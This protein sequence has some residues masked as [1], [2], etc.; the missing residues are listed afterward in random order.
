MPLIKSFFLPP[1]YCHEFYQAFCWLNY[2]KSSPPPPPPPQGRRPGDEALEYSLVL[3]WSI[4]LTVKLPIK[5][6]LKEDKPFNKGQ[7]EI[8]RVYTLYRKSPLKKD[9]LST[10]DQK[11]DPESVLIKRWKVPLYK[12][13]VLKSLT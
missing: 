4:R 10:K 9:N 13:S 2:F 8:T 12:S 3:L 5:D 1:F 6:T 11:A 7:A